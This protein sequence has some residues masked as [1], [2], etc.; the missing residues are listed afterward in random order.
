MEMDELME[1]DGL[2]Q[3]PP[4]NYG[5]DIHNGEI[6]RDAYSP[7]PGNDM[8]EFENDANDFGLSPIQADDQP[9]Y[10]GRAKATLNKIREKLDSNQII[11]LEKATEEVH[12]NT[13]STKAEMIST[14]MDMLMLARNGAV[15][16]TQHAP[17]EKKMWN[18]DG[19]NDSAESKTLSN[20]EMEF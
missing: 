1:E 5:E 7:I 2:Q 13:K 6:F 20:I 3:S 18:I 19:H 14:F 12:G 8:G 4:V 15:K 9:A 10:E 16:I 11:T 17:S